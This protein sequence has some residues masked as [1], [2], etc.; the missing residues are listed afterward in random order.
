MRDE[1]GCALSAR[2]AWLVLGTLAALIL[3]AVPDLGA[4]GWSFRPGHVDAHGILAPIVRAGHRRFDL[5][6][7]RTP[8]V[9]AGLLVAFAAVPGF[10]FLRRRAWPGSRRTD[11]FWRR[12]GIH[13]WGSVE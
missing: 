12:E 1:E 7:I 8:G 13:A 5:G 2:G 10:R 6:L 3:I 4:G 9:L 11:A